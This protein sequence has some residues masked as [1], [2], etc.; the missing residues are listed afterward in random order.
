MTEASPRRPLFY[1]LLPIL[2]AAAVLLVVGQL[3]GTHPVELL[4]ELPPG[5][6]KVAALDLRVTRADGREVLRAHRE[7]QLTGARTF[8]VHTKLPRGKFVLDAW[9]DG[10]PPALEQTFDYN[11]RD[12]AVEVDL[13]PR[14]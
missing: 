4:V 8:V 2:V 9:P 7:R 3:Y 1:R 14:R 11:G 6:E 12:E 10:R 13:A 5:G